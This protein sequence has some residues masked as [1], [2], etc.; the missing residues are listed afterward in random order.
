MSET[1]NQPKIKPRVKPLVWEYDKTADD[2]EAQT[3][4][5]APYYVER[6]YDPDGKSGWVFYMWQSSGYEDVLDSAE[7]AKAAAQ[8]DFEARALSVFE[9][10]A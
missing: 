5:E 8:A 1:A 10:P 9:V 4:F 6:A 3:C 2:W 7:D